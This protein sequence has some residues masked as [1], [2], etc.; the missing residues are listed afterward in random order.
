MAQVFVVSL[1]EGRCSAEKDLPQE[2][3]R[4]AAEADLQ[5]GKPL[6]VKIEETPILLVKSGPGGLCACR[7]L[8]ASRRTV[9]R[10]DD[11]RGDDSVSLAWLSI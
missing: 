10:R 4:A 7:N 6:R 1:L 5:E 3:R 11:R 8:L 9:G 2:F